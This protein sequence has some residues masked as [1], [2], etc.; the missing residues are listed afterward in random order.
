MLRLLSDGGGQSAVAY[1]GIFDA[2]ES[3]QTPFQYNYRF[4][5]RSHILS[6]AYKAVQMVAVVLFCAEVEVKTLF[7]CFMGIQT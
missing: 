7:F 2:A 4:I 3:L 5:S 1:N 6:M